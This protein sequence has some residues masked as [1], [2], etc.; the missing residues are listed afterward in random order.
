VLPICA[1]AG[2]SK[3]R[4]SEKC[5]VP[6]NPGQGIT[7]PRI[8]DSPTPEYPSRVAVD[9]GPTTVT[10]WVIVGS[11][12]RA[13]GPQVIDAPDPEFERAA[14]NAIR[15]WRWKLASQEGKPVPVRVSVEMTFG[16]AR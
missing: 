14:L 3:E 12:G 9:K 4:R 16:R 15:D 7:P 13:C 2:K 8:L 1:V 5:E 10:V 6:Q 11:N